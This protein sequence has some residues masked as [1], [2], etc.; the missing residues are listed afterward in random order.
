MRPTQEH[1][2]HGPGIEAWF[3]G[4]SALILQLVAG[5]SMPCN[6][7]GPP[8]PPR[9]MAKAAQWDEDEGQSGPGMRPE[10]VSL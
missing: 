6:G 8:L 1:Q 4:C 5:R 2:D 10:Y 9:P 3:C 7:L